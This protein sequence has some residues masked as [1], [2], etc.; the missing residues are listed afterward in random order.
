MNCAGEHADWQA[1]A[2]SSPAHGSKHGTTT[3]ATKLASG[4]AHA[5]AAESHGSGGK[6]PGNAGQGGIVSN[7]SD[8]L[9]RAG[10]MTGMSEDSGSAGMSQV[11]VVMHKLNTLTARQGDLQGMLTSLKAALKD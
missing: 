7:R 1:G 4:S 6:V 11:D 3:G 8:V 2:R 5:A 10:S 9:G